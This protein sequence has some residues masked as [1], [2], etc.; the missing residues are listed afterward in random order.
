LRNAADQRNLAAGIG[1]GVGAMSIEVVLQ[2]L[3]TT[4]VVTGVAFA[5]IQVRQYRRERRRAAA[6][7]LLHSFQTPVFAE[8]LNIVYNLPDGLS[9]EA[10]ET[11]LGGRFHIVYSLMTTW[12]SLG[13]LVHMGEIDLDLVEDFFSGPIVISWRKLKGHVEGERAATGRETIEEWFQWLAERLQQREAVASPMPAHL[14]Y[15]NWSPPR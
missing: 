14:E 11:N 5:V 13:I 15:R 2:A 7:E 9:R 1:A 6:I 8:A 4:A 3:E 10:L 12:E